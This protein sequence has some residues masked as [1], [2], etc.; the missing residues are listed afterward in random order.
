[1]HNTHP[2]ASLTSWVTLH[3]VFLTWC[4]KLPV[5]SLTSCVTHLVMPLTSCV[6]FTVA[7][8]ISYVILPLVSDFMFHSTPVSLTLKQSPFI[9][10]F[11]F[12]THSL[13]SHFMCHTPPA[14]LASFVILPL[15]FL[16]LSGLSDFVCHTLLDISVQL[17]NNHWGVSD[18]EDTSHCGTSEFFWCL[19]LCASHSR[20]HLWLHV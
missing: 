13:T 15:V 2:L 5:E 20:Y 11:V 16:N 7:S 6:T 3:T 8:L 17:C 9:S 18:F 14:S 1:M 12:N 4:V 10:D 19:W